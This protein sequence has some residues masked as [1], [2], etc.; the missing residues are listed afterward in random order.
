[1]FHRRQ[2]LAGLLAAGVTPL[3][4]AAQ[5]PVPLSL[6]QQVGRM[7]VLG[8]FGSHPTTPGADKIE[9]HLHARRIGGVLFLGHNLQSR[10]GT[11]E[12]VARFHAAQSD[13]WLALDHE[14]GYVQRLDD[15][16][17]FATIPKAGDV[18]QIGLEEARV[19]YKKAADAFADAGFNFNLAPIAD[20]HDERN[21]VIGRYR[22]AYGSDPETV[23]AYCTAFIDAYKARG[24]A[25]ALKHFPG[26]GRSSVDSHHGI[27]DLTET[28]TLKEAAP[29]GDLI[30][31]GR[32]HAI[33]SG[34]LI[35]RHLDP[36]GAPATLSSPI[37]QGL[38]RQQM[39][40]EGVILTDDLDMAAVRDRYSRR[41]AV[42]AAIASGNDL[43]V[44]SN[45][46]EPDPSLPE[47]II[48]W[49]DEAIT[50]GELDPE[51][52]SLA[53]ARLDKLARDLGRI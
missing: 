51:T 30:R 43:I 36:S 52:I 23:V 9:E 28:W 13:A 33:M 25:C 38:L 48:E 26:H 5:P 8:F 2:I 1:L 47:R 35:N 10:T 53:N 31:N 4:S 3:L 19:I 42:I 15:S 6:E 14:G 12:L 46:A 21:A 17:G 11:E 32:A 44:I 34:H 49:V 40:F 20:L 22:R 41:Q 29:F 27:V 16:L 50:S 7:L 45:T 37:L 39:R 18:S 24:V